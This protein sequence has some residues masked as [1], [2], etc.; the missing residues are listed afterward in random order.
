MPQQHRQIKKHLCFVSSALDEAAAT[1]GS[2]VEEGAAAVGSCPAK[3][4]RFHE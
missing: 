2:C 3:I 4:E 1:V